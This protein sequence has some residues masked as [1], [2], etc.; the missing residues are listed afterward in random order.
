LGGGSV[1]AL[2]ADAWSEAPTQNNKYL[3]LS[4]LSLQ[5]GTQE[6][7]AYLYK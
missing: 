2:Q 4:N 5:Q 6:Y 3:E 1:V 7:P